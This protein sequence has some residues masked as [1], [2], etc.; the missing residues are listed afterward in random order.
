M[1]GFLALLCCWYAAMAFGLT[2]SEMDEM[3]S[4]QT[5]MP[6]SRVKSTLDAYEAKLKSEAA[7]GRAVKMEGFGTMM[8]RAVQGTRTGRTISGGT[9]TYPN[10]K[11]VKKPEV[12]SDTAL[13][14]PEDETIIS[15]YKTNIQRVVNRGGSY[16]S[17]GL[18]SFKMSKLAATKTKPARY[19]TRFSSSKSGAH[20]KF[21]SDP[22][23]Y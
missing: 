8:P 12:V 2:S 20:Q 9:V 4:Q 18:G 5:E 6:T 23:A 16:T 17:R 22:P 19:V 13:I 14:S 7:A 11:L 15:A 1:R 3:I 21:V 10:W